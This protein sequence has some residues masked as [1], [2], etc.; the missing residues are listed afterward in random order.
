MPER[1][2]GESLVCQRLF[3]FPDR[4]ALFREGRTL[5]VVV[6]IVQNIDRIQLSL[7]MAFIAV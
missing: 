4:I 7:V 2:L 1:P 3:T 6:A 5:E